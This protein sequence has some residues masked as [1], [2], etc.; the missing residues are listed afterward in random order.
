MAIYVVGS[1][2]LDLIARVPRLP[3]PG[4][5]LA[6]LSFDMTPGGKGA[7]QALAAQRAGASVL[8]RGAVGQDGNA[9]PALSLLA[10]AGVEL[11]GVQRCET[12]VPTGVALILVDD[13]SGENEIVVVAGANGQPDATCMDGVALSAGDCVLLQL[14]VP[15]MAVDAALAACEQTGALSLLNIAPYHDD[16]VALAARAGIT[17]ANE[18]EFDLLAEAMKLSGDDREARAADFVARTGK[19]MIVTLGGDGAFAANAD[20]IVTVQ[21]PKIEPID[22][23]GAGDTFCG[24]LGTALSE[25]LALRDALT[26]ACA[27]GAAA[28]LKQGA[29]PAIPMRAEAE[30]LTA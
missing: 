6:G 27:A 1:I 3:Q 29:Q 16:A 18:T 4:E 23:V 30:A 24:Y 11:A 7:N 5:T 22:T 26:L 17:I 2:N 9:A 25:G 21:A 14:E 28:C 12:G 20:G 13:S 19:T 15:T 10:D 8:M